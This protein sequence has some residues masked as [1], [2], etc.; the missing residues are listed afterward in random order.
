MGFWWAILPKRESSPRPAMDC[1]LWKDLPSLPVSLDDQA[2]GDDSAG[3]E[4]FR[5]FQVNGM[6]CYRPSNNCRSAR[7]YRPGS[8]S[9]L[10]RSSTVTTAHSFHS[11]NICFI[12]QVSARYCCFRSACFSTTS[13][14]VTTRSQNRKGWVVEKGFSI[15]FV[16]HAGA[17]K[18]PSLFEPLRHD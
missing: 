1:S 16:S 17:S 5:L 18:S 15:G 3:L 8:V 9:A 12:L 6:G 2:P 4:S 7:Y 10:P 11:N 13:A 14:R